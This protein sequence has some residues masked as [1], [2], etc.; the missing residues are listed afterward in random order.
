M[1]VNTAI[2]RNYFVTLRIEKAIKRKIIKYYLIENKAIRMSFV[3]SF[4]KYLSKQNPKKNEH[5]Q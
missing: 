4:I 3:I 2:Y 5:S 1:Q